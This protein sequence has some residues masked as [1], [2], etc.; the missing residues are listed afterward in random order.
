MQSSLYGKVEKAERYAQEP[1][2]IT[3][4]DFSVKFHGT[5]DDHTTCYKDGKWVCNCDFYSQFGRCAHT[6]A[7]ERILD[8]MLPAEAKTNFEF[9]R[10][11]H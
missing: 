3:F 8:R 7:M 4:H 5:N 11:T 10:I 6:M 1:E 2:R 9:A